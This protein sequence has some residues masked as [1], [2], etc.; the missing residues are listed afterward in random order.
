MAHIGIV[1][2]ALVIARRVALIS[3]GKAGA[4]YTR[5]DKVRMVLV[6]LALGLSFPFAQLIICESLFH[7]FETFRL[8]AASD[9]FV[10]G[11]R[12]DI[13]E[14]VGCITAMPNTILVIIL[15]TGWPIPIGIIS[16]YYSGKY[17]LDFSAAIFVNFL[18]LVCTI[19]A[20]FLRRKVF[21]QVLASNPNLTI[22]RYFRLLFMAALE[23]SCTVPLCTTIICLTLTSPIYPYRGLEDLHVNFSRIRQ[24]PFEIWIKWPDVV[25][26]I[27]TQEWVLIGCALV[28]FLI[29]GLTE[30][31]RNHYTNT[32]FAVSRFLRILPRSDE[33]S[34]KR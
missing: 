29:F 21:R 33:T 23:I 34:T 30:E 31:A 18:F 7:L 19:R 32:F 15:S 12:F 25:S 27:L 3:T 5:R 17:Q 8:I 10:Q 22:H 14:G 1:S 16:A 28:Y 24:Y 2:A 9:W 20:F 6:D 13:L 4:V 26:G 11:H